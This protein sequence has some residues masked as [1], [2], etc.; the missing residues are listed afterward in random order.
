MQLWPGTPG[1]CIHFDGTE[2]EL[3][4]EARSQV[5]SKASPVPLSLCRPRGKWWPR[6]QRGQRF[7]Q[8]QDTE[9]ESINWHYKSPVV[10]LKKGKQ[11]T[12]WKRAWERTAESITRTRSVL[13]WHVQDLGGMGTLIPSRIYLLSFLMHHP[14][15]SNVTIYLTTRMPPQVWSNN[16]MGNKNMQEKPRTSLLLERIH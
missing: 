5:Q 16:G 2:S 6:R 11:D 15:R 1:F 7:L 12:Y 3:S 9:L 10:F 14:A 13:V 4:T 8:G